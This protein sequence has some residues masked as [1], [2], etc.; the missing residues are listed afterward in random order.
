MLPSRASARLR[1]TRRACANRAAA[2]IVVL[3]VEQALDLLVRL[4]GIPIRCER[5]LSFPRSGLARLLLLRIRDQFC[6][7]LSGLAD[8]DLLA[9]GDALEQPGQVRLRLM[10]IQDRHNGLDLV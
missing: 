5:D 4:G 1:A 7:R 9:R 10:H 6:D 3:A 2:S 8:D